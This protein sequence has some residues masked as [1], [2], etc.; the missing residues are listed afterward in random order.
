M[1]DDPPDHLPA[2]WAVEVYPLG[3][4]YDLLGLAGFDGPGC[5]DVPGA[6]AARTGLS[7]DGHGDTDEA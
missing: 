7:E 5:K 6:L 3:T 1:P 2:A 4:A